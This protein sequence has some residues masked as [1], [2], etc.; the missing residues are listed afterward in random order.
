MLSS[1]IIVR[2]HSLLFS[3]ISYALQPKFLFHILLILSGDKQFEYKAFHDDSWWEVADDYG[4]SLYSEL[5][6]L[7]NDR[8]D[9]HK[10]KELISNKISDWSSHNGR[11]NKKNF[12]DF[13]GHGSLSRNAS[14]GLFFSSHGD[15]K[16]KEKEK[17]KSEKEKEKERD[18]FGV[19][20]SRSPPV[21]P[22]TSYRVKDVRKGGERG[23]G[24]G[25]TVIEERDLEGQDFVPPS[26]TI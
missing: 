5:T 15:N 4:R 18:L 8:E 20:G 23:G 24:G 26:S 2:A 14:G 7:I 11:R 25:L 19:S 1:L 16:E 22:E 21:G 13:S 12:S 3:F 6:L 10:I 9:K 17:D